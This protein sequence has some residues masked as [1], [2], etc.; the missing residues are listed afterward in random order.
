MQ[1]TQLI[2]QKILNYC[3]FCITSRMSDII[4]VLNRLFFRSKIYQIHGC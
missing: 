3:P 1:Y 2:I 4:D